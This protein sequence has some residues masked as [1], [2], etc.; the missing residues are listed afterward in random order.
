MPGQGKP[1]PQFLKLDG[2]W[3][4]EGFLFLYHSESENVSAGTFTRQ[5]ER[6]D[7]QPCIGFNSAQVAAA[8][9]IDVNTLMEANRNHTLI[10]LGTAAMPPEHGGASATAYGFQIGDKQGYV[11]IEK[12]NEGRA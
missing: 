10:P 12:Y 7:G 9:G 11:T 3:I 6:H 8:L 4:V 1:L 2:E 5:A